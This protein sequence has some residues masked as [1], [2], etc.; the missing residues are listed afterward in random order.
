MINKDFFNDL[1][2]L[3]AD[4]KIDKNYFIESLE[5]AL[6]AAY[7]KNFGEASSASVELNPEKHTIKVYKYKT[8][9][10]TDEEVLD[11]DKEICLADAK[12]IKKSSKVGEQLKE[13]VTPKNFGR[14]SAQI[15]RQV[16]M[17]R[18]RE[19]EQ[20]IAREEL[21][22]KE[23]ELITCIINRLDAGVFYMMNKLIF[24]L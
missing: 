7:K 23:N 13:E 12:L 8:I 20:N 22:E 15:A 18:L 3:A 6:T 24:Q 17:Q 4:K 21:S 16:V 9:V 11:P 1:E 2:D 19:A 10:A 5:L 14:I